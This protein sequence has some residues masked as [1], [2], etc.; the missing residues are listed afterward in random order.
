MK[1]A[2]GVDAQSSHDSTQP[3]ADPAGDSIGS[4]RRP[5][6]Q[7]GTPQGPATI[8]G[9]DRQ[10]VLNPLY[11]SPKG[12]PWEP[13]GQKQ[14]QHAGPG[15]SQGA[16]GLLPVGQGSRL[17]HGAPYRQGQGANG[18]ASK[19]DSQAVP[20]FM[21]GGGSQKGPEAAH[22]IQSVKRAQQDWKPGA[23]F[24]LRPGHGQKLVRRHLPAPPRKML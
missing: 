7:H 13:V 8:H 1:P 20:C 15:A 4:L 11:Q 9:I 21:N 3:D 17:Q 14:K 24:N 12:Q 18:A 10:Q 22:W 6:A 23:D 5:P 19:L 2:G 16:D